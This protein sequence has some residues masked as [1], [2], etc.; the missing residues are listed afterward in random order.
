[1]AALRYSQK[2]NKNIRR[3]RD[4]GIAKK[5]ILVYNIYD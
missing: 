1:M 4:T 5:C 2:I 3:G